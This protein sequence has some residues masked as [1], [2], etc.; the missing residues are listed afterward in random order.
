MESVFPLVAFI[1]V[2]NIYALQITH[3]VSIT[4]SMHQL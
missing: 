3:P 1:D 4:N 2:E